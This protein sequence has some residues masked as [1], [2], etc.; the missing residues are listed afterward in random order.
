MTPLEALI[1]IS[2]GESDTAK[3]IKEMIGQPE[4]ALLVA[5]ELIKGTSL[6]LSPEKVKKVFESFGGAASQSTARRRI[7]NTKVKPTFDGN[8]TDF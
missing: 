8:L 2:L 5:S 3:M 1:Q 6:T 7:D 4:F